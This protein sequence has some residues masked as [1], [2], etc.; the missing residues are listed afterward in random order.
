MYLG[1]PRDLLVYIGAV[2]GVKPL[3]FIVISMIARFPALISSTL[4]G[5]NI[6][7]GNWLIIPL[8]YSVTFIISGIVF[9]IFK[10]REKISK[11]MYE[12]IKF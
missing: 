4:V 7:E 1:T 12:V 11:E 3:N 2:L 10:K 8:I 5:S 9:Y 6:L